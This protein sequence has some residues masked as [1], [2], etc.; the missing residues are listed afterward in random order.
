MNKSLDEKI[1]RALNRDGRLSNARLAREFGV[2][3]A[4]V[5]KR[6]KTLI[7]EGTIVVRAVVNP[8]KMGYQISA[9]VALDVDLTEVSS[10]A[11]QLVDDVNI[12]L[13]VTTFGR[14]DVLFIMDYPDWDSLH[15][16]LEDRLYRIKGIREVEI[17]FVS[18]MPKRYRDIF[19]DVSSAPV[20][21]LDDADCAIIEEL[22]KNGRLGYNVLVEKLGLSVTTIS[23][24]IAS[25]CRRDIMKII[26]VPR[27]SFFGFLSTAYIFLHADYDKI[28]G[29]CREVAKSENVHLVI[30]LLNGYDLLLGVHCTTPEILYHFIR[31]ELARIEG[32]NQIETLVRAEVRKRLVSILR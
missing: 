1:V 18:D 21:V 22:H 15:A 7:D 3:V 26:A 31:D 17:F 9:V 12:S 6:V 13:I 28:D 30:K 5:A 10:I 11:D 23:R 20:P 8:N 19:R 25:L 24:R 16:F 4:T 2:S 14:F 29:I 27:P 32:I